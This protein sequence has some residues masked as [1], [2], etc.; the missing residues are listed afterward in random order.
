MGSVNSYNFVAKLFFF[1][2]VGQPFQRGQLMSIHA[3]VQE[4]D[5]CQQFPLMSRRTTADYVAVCTLFII[6]LKC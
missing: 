6:N 2:I 4:D 3:F 1:Q 5:E